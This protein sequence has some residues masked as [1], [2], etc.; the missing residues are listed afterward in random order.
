MK[1]QPLALTMMIKKRRV[2]K[3]RRVEKEG[4]ISELRSYVRQEGVFEDKLAEIS[5]NEFTPS[6]GGGNHREW[7]EWCDF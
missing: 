2:A 4:Y 7:G 5:K 3:D 1:R 6:F